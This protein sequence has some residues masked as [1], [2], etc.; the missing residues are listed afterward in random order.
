M[1][2][3]EM[4]CDHGI[5][6]HPNKTDKTDETDYTENMDGK[7]VCME[8]GEILREY[9]FVHNFQYYH[10]GHRRVEHCTQKYFKKAVLAFSEE[11]SSPDFDQSILMEYFVEQERVL[12]KVI[13]N[14]ERKNSLNV[15]YK[16][17]KLLQF[18]GISSEL[19]TPKTVNTLKRH[20]ETM[21]KV[22]KLLDWEWVQTSFKHIFEKARTVFSE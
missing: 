22:W 5:T 16:L 8:C 11:K 18:Q 10:G 12:E 6:D 17:Y 3:F 20:D 19:K 14:S 15:N 7:I 21:K 9:T 1:N 4:E 13:A 2:I